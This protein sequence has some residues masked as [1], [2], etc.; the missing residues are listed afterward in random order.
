MPLSGWKGTLSVRVIQAPARAVRSRRWRVSRLSVGRARPG[1][2]RCGRSGGASSPGPVLTASGGRRCASPRGLAQGC[3]SARAAPRGA[4]S[5]RARSRAAAAPLA[6]PSC[7]LSLLLPLARPPARGSQPPG[8]P[9]GGRGSS[10]LGLHAPAAA[11]TPRRACT[12][13]RRLQRAAARMHRPLLLLLQALGVGGGEAGE[14]RQPRRRQRAA[15][16]RMQSRGP[17]RREITGPGGAGRTWEWPGGRYTG[18]ASSR[19][20]A[21]AAR[22]GLSRAHGPWRRAGAPGASASRRLAR[23]GSSPRL[24]PGCRAQRPAGGGPGSSPPPDGARSLSAE[25]PARQSCPLLRSGPTDRRERRQRPRRL[26]PRPP[27]AIQPNQRRPRGGY[28]GDAA[29]RPAGGGARGRHARFSRQNSK[30]GRAAL[31]PPPPSWGGAGPTSR[32]LQLPACSAPA[33]GGGA[34]NWG[35]EHARIC[36]PFVGTQRWKNQYPLWSAYLGQGTVLR[37]LSALFHIIL[38]TTL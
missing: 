8:P 26:A 5:A 12:G 10:P 3:S 1:P 21:G 38:E 23:A 29:P 25:P 35:A 14:Q 33:P 24:R 17:R 13:P 34:P 22:A 28:Q 30:A 37:A 32:G 9:G 4:L 20:A 27:P 2:G 15:E 6:G 11:P 36:S 19:A 7:S 18:R 16:A 31:Q